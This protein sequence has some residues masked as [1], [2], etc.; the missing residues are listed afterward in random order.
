MSRLRVMVREA[1]RETLRGEPE[2]VVSAAAAIGHAE[3]PTHAASALAAGSGT[4]SGLAAVTCPDNTCSPGT[5]PPPPTAHV[6]SLGD[7]PSLSD[8][9]DVLITVPASIR[10]AITEHKFVN[11][12]LLLSDNATPQPEADHF[13]VVA[14]RIQVASDTKQVYSFSAWSSRSGSPVV[15]GSS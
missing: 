14:G 10:H 13:L 9:G 15:P 4:T 12:A 8:T 3:V 1:V 6:H 7:R 2:A 11:L 5:E